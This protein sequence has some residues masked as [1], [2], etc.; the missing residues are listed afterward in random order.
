[1][2]G[3][4]KLD[5][6]GRYV[7]RPADE[8]E[9]KRAGQIARAAW[10]PIHEV[11]IQIRGKAMHDVLCANWADEKE[12]AVVNHWKRTPEWFRVVE[13]TAS[14]EVVAFVTFRMDRE[15]FLGLILNNAVAP[16][17]QGK[18][19]GTLMYSHVLDLFRSEGLRFASV[20]TGLDE[21]H[22]PARRAYEKAGFNIQQPTVTYYQYL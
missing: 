13:D 5:P 9:A 2:S 11:S 17:A 19:L 10:V 14:R 20:G 1:M 4:V 8:K 3:K 6:E 16:E 12:A 21:G 22:A 7:I 15:K 18:G